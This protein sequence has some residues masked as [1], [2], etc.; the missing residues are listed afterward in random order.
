MTPETYAY[1]IRIRNA[2]IR[3]AVYGGFIALLIIGAIVFF[4]VQASNGGR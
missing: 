4:I 3:G 1:L 2:M